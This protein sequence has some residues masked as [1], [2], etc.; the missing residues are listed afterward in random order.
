MTVATSGK[1][2][3]YH[4]N[5]KLPVYARTSTR[6]DTQEIVNALLD[7]ELDDDMICSMQPVNV[8]NSVVFIV[9]LGKL[10]NVKDPELDDDMI[11]SMQPVNVEN[12]VVFIVH[13]GKLK[14]VKDV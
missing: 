14:N 2:D 12:S 4:G 7:P 11:C 10:K 8:E 9:H 1:G 5:T 13:L 6:M 3:F